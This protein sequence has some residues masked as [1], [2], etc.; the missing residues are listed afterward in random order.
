MATWRSTEYTELVEGSPVKRFLTDQGQVTRRISVSGS[1][2]LY[3]Q[4]ARDFI[5]YAEVTTEGGVNV[6]RR[7]IPHSFPDLPK[8]FCTGIPVCEG[9]GHRSKVNDVAV[10]EKELFTA[11]YSTPTYYILD[12][13]ALQ[14]LHDTLTPDEGVAIAA[15]W[16]TSRYITKQVRQ[17]SRMLILNRGLMKPSDNPNKPI[18]EG[19]PFVEYAADIMYTWHQVP[20]AAL[21]QVAHREG[22]GTINDAVFDG[23][24]AGTLLS[25]TPDPKPFTDQFGNRMFDIQYR[26]KFLPRWE[27]PTATPLVATGHNY[28]LQPDGIQPNIT[29][30]YKQVDSKGNGTGTK[31][32]RSYDFTK[33]FRP[34]QP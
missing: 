21:P 27:D 2:Q 13:A 5:G 4:A 6:L 23:Y 9:L 7:N 10:Y 14:A 34:D 18:P 31:L 24:P 28:I 15:G 19:V 25:E 3:I 11:I 30:K 32:Y 33:F 17:A 8:M 26:F 29:L 16:L 1:D 22:P 12:D 20:E